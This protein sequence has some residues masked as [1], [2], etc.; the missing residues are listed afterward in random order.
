MP[1]RRKHKY[2]IIARTSPWK[3]SEFVALG[4][5]KW[6]YERDLTLPLSVRSLGK[7]AAQ[8]KLNLGKRE[9]S[10]HTVRIL[11][12]NSELTSFCDITATKKWDNLKNCPTEEFA[13]GIRSI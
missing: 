1:R 4:Y 5:R 11:L 7:W 10:D 12:G 13:N 3:F 6:P 8:V 9:D 2:I